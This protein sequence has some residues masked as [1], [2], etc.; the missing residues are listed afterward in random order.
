M[1]NLLVLFVNEFPYNNSEPFLEAEYP[2]YKEY[3]D[4]VL[5]VTNRPT[6]VGFRGEKTREVND[7]AVEILESAFDRGL[8]GKLALFWAALSDKN[9]YSE[10][11]RIIFRHH[12][13]PI[14][15]RFLLTSIGKANLCVKLAYRRCRELEAEGYQ[16]AAAY[17]Y[18]VSHPA[19]AAVKFS[20][21]YYGGRLYTVSRAHRFD[22]YEHRSPGGYI[23]CRR[24]VLSGLDEIASISEDGRRY[25]ET[26]H[27]TWPMH[28]TV[29]RLGAV[30]VGCFRPVERGDVF[31]IVSCS[32]AVPVKRI[33]RIIQAL[34]CMPDV[35][36]EWTHCGGGELL[37]EIQKQAALLPD[38]IRCVFTDTVP[39]TAVYE[40]YRE[41]AYHVFVNVSES[42]GVP[43]SIMEAMS[44]GLPVIATDVGG[45]AEIIDEGRTGYLLRPD[46]TD[47]ELVACLHRII[48][49]DD[50]AYTAMRRRAREKFEQEYNAIPNYRAFLQALRENTEK[51]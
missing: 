29:R 41:H 34:A 30:D 27:P 22:L 43:V 37:G 25:L 7:P 36:I 8:R 33:H 15:F 20:R 2:L 51:H 47:E 40:L 21:K 24:Y 14:S 12:A 44:F 1:K 9:T 23:F 6:A 39:N 35:A 4:K 5:I 18:W 46:F 11:V 3:F 42:E 10:I 28:I 50:G 48:H 38:N 19:Y 31:R 49:M 13:L 16:P 26:A 17:A 45:T 32:R